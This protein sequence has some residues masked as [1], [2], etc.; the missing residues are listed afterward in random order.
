MHF[1]TEHL[2]QATN[3]KCSCADGATVSFRRRRPSLLWRCAA[4]LLASSNEHAF[5]DRSW[6]WALFYACPHRSRRRLALKLLSLSPHYWIYQWTNRYDEAFTRNQVLELE[7]QRNAYSRCE[8]F[9][10]LVVPFLRHEMTV[11]DFGCGPGFLARQLSTQV[12]SVWA[13]DVSRGVIECA[14]RLN[15][16]SN[17]RYCTNHSS[18]LRSIG[19][20]SVDFVCS[21]A[22]VQHLR[23]EQT[24]EFFREF[25]RV[26]RP[27][28]RGMLHFISQENCECLDQGLLSSCTDTRLKLRIVYYRREDIAVMLD[29]AG[30]TSI[31]VHD[32]SR[33]A[34]ISDDIGK[35]QLATFQ[36]PV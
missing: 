16:A 32:I 11:L 15:P 7:F 34:D 2:K 18:D 12:R 13:T 3:N 24:M 31:E 28:G 26:L 14:R 10:K 19:D 27:E 5:L 29:R 1:V 17:I 36:R 9:S 22:V 25:F 23:T 35:Q 8:I 20:A 6:I 33:L 30:M 4:W 21:F